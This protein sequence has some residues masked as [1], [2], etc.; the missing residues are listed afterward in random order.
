VVY[1]QVNLRPGYGWFGDYG[2]D[3]LSRLYRKVVS[4][5]RERYLAEQNRPVSAAEKMQRL[6]GLENQ[7]K[8]V[9]AAQDEQGRWIRNGK[10][11]TSTFIRNMRVLCDYL[12][13]VGEN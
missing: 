7:V 3:A 4:L 8:R 2:G 10:I 6:R 12:E 9:M 11:E 5:G 1:E 13:M